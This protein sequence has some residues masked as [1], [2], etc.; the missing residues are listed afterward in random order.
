MAQTTLAE[1]YLNYS[2]RSV[3][4]YNDAIAHGQRRGQAFFNALSKADQKVLRTTGLD[5]FYT[6]SD[7]E[8]ADT[9]EVLLYWEG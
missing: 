9:V 2:G 7:S 4:D 6:D 5:T 1:D 8:I 3:W